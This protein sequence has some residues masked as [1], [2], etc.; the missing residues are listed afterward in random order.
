MQ[1]LCFIKFYIYK[2]TLD[3]GSKISL[4]NKNI[5]ATLFEIKFIRN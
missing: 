5:I 4:R 1:I 3:T 2:I